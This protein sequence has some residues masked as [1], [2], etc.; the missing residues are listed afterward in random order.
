MS[1]FVLELVDPFS[2]S[3]FKLKNF[4]YSFFKPSLIMPW[5]RKIMLC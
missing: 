2:P 5:R 3:V 1:N 4:F